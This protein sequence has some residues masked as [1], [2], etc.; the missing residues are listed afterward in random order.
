MNLICLFL[1]F[2]CFVCFCCDSVH[3]AHRPHERL[4]WTREAV[5]AQRG[6]QIPDGE[7][8]LRA[9]RRARRLGV[10][11]RSCVWSF[12]RWFICLFIYLFIYLFSYS[13]IY[14]FVDLLI[15]WLICLFVLFD[16]MFLI[17]WKGHSW[18]GEID[19]EID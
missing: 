18:I 9:A 8:F 17:K 15:D 3:F 1:F 6:A 13:V 4:L 11:R 2:I 14:L 7:H 5:T 12:G 19:C 10:W 16:K